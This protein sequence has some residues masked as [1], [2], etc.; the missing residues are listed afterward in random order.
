MKKMKLIKILRNQIFTFCFDEELE[1]FYLLVQEKIIN[2][3]L[4][5]LCELTSLQY[6]NYLDEEDNIINS[7]LISKNGVLLLSTKG[8]I[9]V[10]KPYQSTPDNM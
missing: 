8:Q 10:Y 2:F 1:V 5:T 7:S 4:K 9:L 3:S 6:L